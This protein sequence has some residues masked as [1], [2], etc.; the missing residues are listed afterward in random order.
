MDGSRGPVG[1]G[2]PVDGP[3]LG[4]RGPVG[5]GA[6]VDGSTLGPASPPIC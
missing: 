5:G 1:G 3:A 4:P 6:P 2:A